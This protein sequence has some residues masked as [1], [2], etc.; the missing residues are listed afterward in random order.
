MPRYSAPPFSSGTLPIAE[1][2]LA[3]M[4]SHPD[5]DVALSFAGEDRD[6]V[7]EVARILRDH[8]VA[9]FYDRFETGHLWGRDLYAHLTSVYRSARFTIVFVSE[10]YA[11]KR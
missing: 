3:R 8:G 5:Y 11:T 6:Y 1:G 10:H 2:R 9:V 7:D 4:N